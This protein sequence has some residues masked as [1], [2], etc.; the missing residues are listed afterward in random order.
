[1]RM[2][3]RPPYICTILKMETALPQIAAIYGWEEDLRLRKCNEKKEA[4]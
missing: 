4:G 3:C 1:M 2:H